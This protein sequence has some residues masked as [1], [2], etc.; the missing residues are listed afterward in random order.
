MKSDSAHETRI[1]IVGAGFGGLA[2]AKRLK[3]V[4][5]QVTLIDR[6]NHH[7]FQPLLYQVASAAL[8]AANIAVP[9]REVV[10]ERENFRVVM[11]EVQGIDRAARCVK[12]TCGSYPY[13]YL[14]VATGARHSY[15][16]HPEW[17]TVAP[18]LKTVEDALAIRHKVLS[19]FEAAEIETSEAR[20]KVLLT[21]VLVGGGPT[22]VEMAGAIAELGRQAMARDFKRISPRDVRVVLLEAAPRLL[23]TFSESL[24][25]YTQRA[26]ERIGVEVR[27]NAMVTKIDDSGVE[28]GAERISSGTVIWTA[29][30]KPSPA[31]QWLGVEPDRLGRVPVTKH[32]TLADDENI[33]VIGDTAAVPDGDGK[34]LP[35]LAAV[36]MQEG[37]YVARALKHKIRTGRAIERHFHYLNKGYL[38]TIG[39]D[40]AVAQLG[41][42]HFTGPIAWLL[43]GVVHI[44]YL[45]DFRNRVLVM[46]QWFWAWLT[47][48]RGSR[49][50][51]STQPACKLPRSS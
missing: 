19:A 25:L 3:G 29:G 24:A 42:W 28:I 45:I 5:A 37:R 35:G 22:G 20:R 33:F 12:T 4:K 47:F 1:V 40:R 27:L 34:P 36:A 7:L 17:E 44:L 14:L 39:R 10:G 16:N 46:L 32:L 48:H 23:A 30:V 6:Q 43:W 31:A 50:I 38:A 8:S 15:F 2:A 13:D 26:L 9:V 41:H 21:F 11:D 51:T 18:G 49:L